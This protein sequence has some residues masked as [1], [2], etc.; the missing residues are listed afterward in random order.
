MATTLQV[1]VQACLQYPF[2][3][4]PDQLLVPSG[5]SVGTGAAAVI[6]MFLL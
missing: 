6:V 3:N 2:R 4:F 1:L 5:R